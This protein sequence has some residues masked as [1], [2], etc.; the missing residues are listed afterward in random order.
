[1]AQLGAQRRQAR[2]DRKRLNEAAAHLGISPAELTMLVLRAFVDML[3][4]EE[5][6]LTLPLAFSQVPASA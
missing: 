2:R 3:E 5:G 4:E 6:E 1:M